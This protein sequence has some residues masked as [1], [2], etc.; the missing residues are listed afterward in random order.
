MCVTLIP[1]QVRGFMVLPIRNN[2]ANIKIQ[3]T[4]ARFYINENRFEE[5][6]EIYSRILD[7][8][9]DDVEVLMV[10]GNLYLAAGNGPTAERLFRRALEIDSSDPVIAHQIELAHLEIN[11]ELQDEAVPTSSDAVRRLLQQLTGREQTVSDEELERAADLLAHIVGS[12]NP[13]IEVASRLD[14]IDDLLP[15]LIDLN[16]QQAKADGHPELAEALYGLKINI[17]LQKSVKNNQKS[18]SSGFKLEKNW[19]PSYK[20]TVLVLSSEPSNASTGRL[21]ILKE[22]LQ[23]HGCKVVEEYDARDKPDVAIIG[24]PFHSPSLMECIATISTDKVPIIV[25]MDKDYENL[26]VT[27]DDYDIKGIHSPS[28]ERAYASALLLADLI[29]VPSAFMAENLRKDGYPV[30]VIPEGWSTENFFWR[31][32]IQDRTV[33]RMGW[34]GHTGGMEDL[35]YIRRVLIR[36]LREFENELSLVI[37]GNPEA[38]RMFENIPEKNKIFLPYLT[39]EELPYMLN[40]VDILLVPHRKTPFYLTSSDEIVMLAGIKQIPWIATPSPAFEKWGKGGI[41]ADTTDDWHSNLRN[42]IMYPEL[43]K[44]LA[45]EGRLRAEDREMKIHVSEWMKTLSFVSSINQDGIQG[46]MSRG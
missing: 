4:M 14:E 20:G 12:A 36:L 1:Y 34:F 33:V 30:A 3:K 40:Q 11:P 8:R 26:P 29:T 27:N 45:A 9:P 28:V 32:S 24:N 38:Y 39:K 19:E 22:A 41:L 43:R 5:A 13:A 6:L 17:S 35:A 42:L 25:D 44:E 31:N 18:S 21:K 2:D 23:A 10:L 37:V 7:D 46:S 15:A 16:I